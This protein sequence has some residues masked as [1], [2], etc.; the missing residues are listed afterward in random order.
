MKSILQMHKSTICELG[1][2]KMEK[3]RRE[4]GK[5]KKGAGA[6]DVLATAFHV[7]ARER[8]GGRGE[9]EKKEH[10]PIRFLLTGEPGPRRGGGKERK[11]ILFHSDLVRERKREKTGK[12]GK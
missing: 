8:T 3:G 2:V 9:G 6:E 5:G 4:K 11:K 10:G 1:R 12:K 7:S